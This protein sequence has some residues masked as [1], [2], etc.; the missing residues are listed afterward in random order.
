MMFIT[1]TLHTRPHSNRIA[2]HKAASV[3]AELGLQ[4]ALVTIKEK[5]SEAL[6]SRDPKPLIEALEIAR[7]DESL[8]DEARRRMVGLLVCAQSYLLY[9]CDE[10]PRAQALVE[11]VYWQMIDDCRGSG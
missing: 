11:P 4:E 7:G 10:Y 3:R 9:T 5:L 1:V 2:K 8:N 6:A